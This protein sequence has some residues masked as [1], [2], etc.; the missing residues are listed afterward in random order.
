MPGIRRVATV[1]D[2]ADE[3]HA[4]HGDAS[5]I[6]IDGIDG[7]GKTPFARRLAELLGGTAVEVDQFV[8]KQQGKYVPFVQVDRL[9][10]TV[11]CAARPV[12]IDAVCLLAVCER[13]AVQPDLLIYIK[14]VS[15]TG[16]WQDQDTCDPDEDEEA[17]LTRL[18]EE[19]ARFAPFVEAAGDDPGDDGHTAGLT[20]LREEIIRYHCRYRPSRRANIVVLRQEDGR[21]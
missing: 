6:G 21:F 12:L 10:E 2:A 17:L 3:I 18:S 20:P 8:E 9:S 15:S 13:I 5:I 4:H 11:A 16:H 7:T 14:R 1:A 19:A